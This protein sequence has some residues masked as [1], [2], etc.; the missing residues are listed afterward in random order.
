MIILAVVFQNPAE[1]IFIDH[2]HMV[3][4]LSTEARRQSPFASVMRLFS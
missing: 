1:M 4:A 3:E 2:D